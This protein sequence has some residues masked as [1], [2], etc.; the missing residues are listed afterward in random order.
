MKGKWLKRKNSGKAKYVYTVHGSA[1]EIAEYVEHQGENV[2]YLQSDG[3]IGVDETGTPVFYSTKIVGKN[4]TLRFSEDLYDGA[5]GYIAEVNFE[6][7]VYMDA[8]SS[9]FT[10]NDDTNTSSEREEEDEPKSAATANLQE[11]Q[12][13]PKVT[14]KG[15]SRKTQ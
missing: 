7:A 1:K 6:D 14:G 2:R 13:K 10:S 5:G 12:A 3:S 9:Q 11:P 15:G 4:P 8:V